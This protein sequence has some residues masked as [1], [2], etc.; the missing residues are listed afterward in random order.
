M[1]SAGRAAATDPTNDQ[2]TRTGGGLPSP[3]EPA[4]TKPCGKALSLAIRIRPEPPGGIR[5][6]RNS[7]LVDGDEPTGQSTCPKAFEALGDL[8]R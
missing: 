1:V 5:R 4:A 7:V 2:G 8:H 3:V 6:E